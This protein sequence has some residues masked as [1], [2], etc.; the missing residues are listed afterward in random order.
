MKN[1][2]LDD[3]MSVLLDT[4]ADIKQLNVDD[5]LDDRSIRIYYNTPAEGI[6]A[7]GEVMICDN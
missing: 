2:S 5:L 1:A 7:V 4:T 3:L 6:D